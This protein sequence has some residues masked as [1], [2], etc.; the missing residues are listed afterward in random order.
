MFFASHHQNHYP[1]YNTPV[2]KQIKPKQIH[3][4]QQ[5]TQVSNK[6]AE[7]DTEEPRQVISTVS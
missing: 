4:K 6:Q 7:D 1:T 3:K 5:D 2:Y